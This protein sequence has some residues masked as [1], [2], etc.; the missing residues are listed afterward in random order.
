M[1]DPAY[2]GEVC[3]LAIFTAIVCLPLIA[4]YVLGLVGGYE[5]A[6]L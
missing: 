4:R 3:A 6:E 2:P 1:E 5:T